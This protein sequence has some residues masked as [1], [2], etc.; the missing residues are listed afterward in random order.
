VR[1]GSA[2]WLD[3]AREGMASISRT[4]IASV[5]GT[6]ITGNRVEGIL[7]ERSSHA[8]IGN[9]T[10]I[11][12]N[13]GNGITALHSS[14]VILELPGLPQ[15][16]KTDADSPNCGVGLSC[17][18]GGSVSKVLGTLTAG[19]PLALLH[20]ASYM[21]QCTH[22]NKDCRSF[23]FSGIS[24]HTTRGKAL[25]QS[26]T[27]GERMVPVP[28]SPSATGLKERRLAACRWQT[29]ASDLAELW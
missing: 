5:V 19:H 14:S 22:I 25:V 26:G 2:W 13:Q 18:V 7:V 8:E 28:L 24:A 20:R 4:A 3:S 11:S 16:N 21:C 15:P 10:I 12:G 9:N 23:C 1:T 27:C 6:T 29:Y 17:T